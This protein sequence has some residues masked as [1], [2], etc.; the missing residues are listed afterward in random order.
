MASINRYSY[1]TEYGLELDGKFT[2]FRTKALAIRTGKF[3]YKVDN[4]VKLIERSIT[5]LIS[6][7]KGDSKVIEIIDHDRTILIK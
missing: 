4:N 7:K 1:R 6:S 5:W 2:K 3:L